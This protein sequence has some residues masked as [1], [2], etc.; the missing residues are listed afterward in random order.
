MRWPWKRDPVV[1]LDIPPELLLIDP[2][3]VGAE[4]G[5][6][7]YKPR[8][9]PEVVDWCNQQKIKFWGVGPVGFYASLCPTKA[10]CL[11]RERD[12]VLFKLMWF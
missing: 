3:F 1:H 5:H 6:S 10:W 8:L 9:R 12:A 7:H 4:G 2:F 11:M